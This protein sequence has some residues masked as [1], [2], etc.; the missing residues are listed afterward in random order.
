[1]CVHYYSSR[2]RRWWGEIA[3]YRTVITILRYIIVLIAGTAG[4]AL[5]IGCCRKLDFREISFSFNYN[6]YYYY[7]YLVRRSSIPKVN[8]ILQSPLCRYIIHRVYNIAAVSYIYLKIRVEQ[9][10]IHI[11]IYIVVYVRCVGYSLPRLPTILAGIPIMCNII[12]G[13]FCSIRT[14]MSGEGEDKQGFL[15]ETLLQ[16][17]LGFIASKSTRYIYIYIY[18]L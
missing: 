14:A 17:F 4:N 9:N 15:H 10:Y 11:Y 6:Y 18:I 3:F 12:V 8:N 1:L 2:V 5:R 13:F 7:Y 16:M